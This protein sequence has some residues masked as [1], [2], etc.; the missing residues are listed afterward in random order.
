LFGLLA[1]SS[2]INN[3]VASREIMRAIQYLTIGIGPFCHGRAA[4]EL[5]I[6]DDIPL[7]TPMPGAD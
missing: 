6:T 2:V 5:R 3:P 4:A 1:G 7:L